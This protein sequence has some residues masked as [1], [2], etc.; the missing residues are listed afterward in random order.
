MAA[1]QRELAHDPLGALPPSASDSRSKSP[2]SASFFYESPRSPSARAPKTGG[3]DGHDR[4][5]DVILVLEAH[6]EREQI[7]AV[8]R[9]ALG[10]MLTNWAVHVLVHLG[11]T[12]ALRRPAACGM[13]KIELR[14]SSRLSARNCDHICSW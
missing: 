12:R 13:G 7:G 11:Q 6:L 5:V 4:R 9:A 3:A 10:K 2:T 14:A 8:M 1:A